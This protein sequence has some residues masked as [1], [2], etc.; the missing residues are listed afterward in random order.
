MN[1]ALTAA[2]R[3]IEELHERLRRRE[4]QGKAGHGSLNPIRCVNLRDF[5]ELCPELIR[6]G[7]IFRS[8]QLMV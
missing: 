1:G 3:G 2:Q 8:S 4:E 6:Q 7:V 5:G